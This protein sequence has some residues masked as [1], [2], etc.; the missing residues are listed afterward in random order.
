MNTL[1]L[2][3]Q[4][5]RNSKRKSRNSTKLKMVQVWIISGMTRDK[6][7][8]VSWSRHYI[9]MQKFSKRNRL[10]SSIQVCHTEIP[11]SKG[12]CKIIPTWIAKFMLSL[13]LCLNYSFSQFFIR[14]KSPFFL[15]SWQ[16]KFFRLIRTSKSLC[17][18]QALANIIVY[19][20]QS[21]IKTFINTC[22]IQ[23]WKKS[24]MQFHKLSIERSSRIQ[25][26]NLSRLPFWNKLLSFWK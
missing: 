6:G 19:K 18:S 20:L 24:H 16:S 13:K 17:N 21:M 23:S 22:F 15:N 4:M 11:Q 9:L 12:S 8:Y 7:I 10:D 3:T 2:S 14:R 26:E 5:N 1:K 25:Q